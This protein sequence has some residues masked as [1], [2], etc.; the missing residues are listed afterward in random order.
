MVHEHRL[1]DEAAPRLADLLGRE[2]VVVVV[3]P[4]GDRT[5]ADVEKALLG[6]VVE[7]RPVGTLHEAIAPSGDL[8]LHDLEVRVFEHGHTLRW[9][10][11]P[12]DRTKVGEPA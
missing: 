6:G 7:H 5:R 8:G 3:A 1:A 11:L 4:R 12:L 10:H 2:L 9:T